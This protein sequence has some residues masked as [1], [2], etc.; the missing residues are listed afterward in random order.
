MIPI[1]FDLEP[2]DPTLM[3]LL[4]AARVWIALTPGARAPGPTPRELVARWPDVAERPWWPD[5]PYGPLPVGVDWLAVRAAL[6]RRRLA[7]GSWR[8]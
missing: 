1:A 3:Q 4:F 5:W 6:E 7:Y 2:D 8:A